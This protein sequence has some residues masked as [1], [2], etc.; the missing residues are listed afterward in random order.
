MKTSDDDEG[1]VHGKY[2]M[3][4]EPS[5]RAQAYIEVAKRKLD[6]R[7]ASFG[8]IV[9]LCHFL[10]RVSNEVELDDAVELKLLYLLTLQQTLDKIPSFQQNEPHYVDWLNNHNAEIEYKDRWIVKK[11][12]FQQLHDKYSFLPI[13]DR[14]LQE[15]PD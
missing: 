5:E 11:E 7:N 12:Q 2:T 8:D 14:I 15:A 13:A 10:A 4:L 1:W 9:D 3:S 6:S